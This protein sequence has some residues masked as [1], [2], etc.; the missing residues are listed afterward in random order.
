MIRKRVILRD[1]RE[2]PKL[3]IEMIIKTI[4][5]LCLVWLPAAGL[6]RTSVSHYSK[7]QMMPLFPRNVRASGA[8]GKIGCSGERRTPHLASGALVRRSLFVNYGRV[9]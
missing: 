2:N 4:G 3:L 5:I 6:R 7:F 9:N 8:H 1:S